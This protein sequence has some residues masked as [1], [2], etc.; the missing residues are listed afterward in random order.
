MATSHAVRSA[1]AFRAT[2]PAHIQNSQIDSGFVTLTG[3]AP[4]DARQNSICV[5]WHRSGSSDATLM[6]EDFYEVLQISPN[7]E[8]DT[9]HRVYR[10]LAQRFHPDNSDTGNDG[11]F[12]AI[13]E[14]YATLSDPSRRAQYDI[15]YH[16]MRQ[17]RW[18]MLS[19]GKKAENDFELEQ[20]ARLTILEVLYTR[21]R[22]EAND[23]SL[24]ILDLEAMLGR[25]REHL[26]FSVWYLMQKGFVKRSDDSRLTITADGVEHLE[27]NY[28]GN[29]QRRLEAGSPV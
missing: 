4:R 15:A 21:R 12:L 25:P 1:K 5:M 19:N 11:R 13:Q 16:Q 9:V 3:G 28:K 18:R 27:Q 20:I 2:S 29:L 22:S 8:P 10:L 17:D 7:A 23:H 24:F 14:A 26:E 6:T